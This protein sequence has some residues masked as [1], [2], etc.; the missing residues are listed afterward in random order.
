VTVETP[1]RNGH[2]NLFRTD[3]AITYIDEVNALYRTIYDNYD[4]QIPYGIKKDFYDNVDRML[5]QELEPS[6]MRTIDGF[7]DDALRR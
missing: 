1:G 2:N 6:L 4:G 3:E 7:I 5:L